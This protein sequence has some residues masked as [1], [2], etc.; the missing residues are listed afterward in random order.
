MRPLPKMDIYVQIASGTSM[1]RKLTIA[2]LLVFAPTGQPVADD[3][4]T[5]TYRVVNVYPHDKNAYTQGL[6]FRKGELYESTGL[7]GASSVRRVS[8][9]T[10]KVLRKLDLAKEY[11]GEGIVDWGDRLIHVTW[12]SG[13]GF[14]FA[15]DN[16][17]EQDTFRI[18]GEGWGLT[19]NESHIIMSDGTEKLRFLDPDTLQQKG[20]ISVS[21]RGRKLRYL[22]ELEWID[23]SVF[24]NVWQTDWIVRIDPETGNVTAL[25]DLSGI[26][27]DSNRQPGFTGV[28]NGIAYD[29]ETSRLF[30]TGKNWPSL[31]EIMLVDR[32]TSLAD[33]E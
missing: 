2:S 4:I 23:G 32:K 6:F 13:K 27:P 17:A 19:R 14:V 18:A 9:R 12:R 20:S 22:N 16:F 7:Y 3:V 26:L 28:L 11:F 8:L 15:L 1:F 25:V 33:A 31:F 30:V 10:G 29:A 5:Y 24:A 21:L